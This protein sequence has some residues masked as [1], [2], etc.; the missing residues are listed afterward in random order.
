MKAITLLVALAATAV[1]LPVAEPITKPEVDVQDLERR[2]SVGTTS[3]EF[4]NGGCRD[5]I[6][7]FARGSTE[8]GNM[9]RN[10]SLQSFDTTSC[11]PSAL[12]S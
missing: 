5:I 1:A 7:F 10:L 3:N 12:S 11:L 9:V 2:Q 6:W 8:V 4:K